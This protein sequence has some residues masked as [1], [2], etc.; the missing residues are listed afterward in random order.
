MRQAYRSDIDGLR[1]VAVLAV[2]FYH[3]GMGVPGGFTGVD[4]FFVISG[5]L[6]TSNLKRDIER[7]NFSILGFYD[8]RIRRIVPAL[9]VMI[10]V[11]LIA[12]WFLLTPGDYAAAGQS[13]TYAAFGLSNLYFLLH[14]GY[15]DRVAEMQPLLHTWSLGVEEQF[16]LVWPVL[17][18]IGMKIV[19]FKR[20][21]LALFGLALLLAFAYGV[22][23]TQH[24]PTRGFYLPHARAWELAIGAI[25]AFMPMVR[26]PFMAGIM[27]VAGI[28]LLGWS[29][30]GLNSTD[31]FPGA[32]AIYA[33]GGAALLAWPKPGW[34]IAATLTSP[35]L[36][37]IGL[38]SYS[39]YLWHWPVLVLFRTYDD[40]ATPTLPQTLA[41]AAVSILLAIA[42]YWFVERPIR[43]MRPIRWTTV[44]SGLACCA[45]V[46]SGSYA[47]SAHE[48]FPQR[49]GKKVA[50][51]SSLEAMWDWTC[52][53]TI[54]FPELPDAACVFGAPWG[55]A[56][57]R[58]LIW[59]DSHSQVM[60]PILNDIAKRKDVSVVLFRSCPPITD[61]EFISEHYPNIP[62]YTDICRTE[63][64]DGARFLADHS[65]ISFLIAASDWF[66]L[67]PQ[68]YGPSSKDGFE[69]MKRGL[70][71]FV[72]DFS[73]PTR[74][75][76][77]I[78]TV[79]QYLNDPVACA[80]G[81]IGPLLRNPCP[82]YRTT[83]PRALFEKRQGQEYEVFHEIAA[84][85]PSV[86]VIFSGERMC[87]EEDCI[88]TLDGQFL[89]RDKTHLRRN[90]HPET[91]S[92]LANILG[93]AKVFEQA[94]A[95]AVVTAHR[96]VPP[97]N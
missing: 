25:L 31:L 69:L 88:S 48:G 95:K 65:D 22:I 70:L 83:I 73:A 32:N 9:L 49:L 42:S 10:A 93:I 45:V 75:I 5:F 3:Y 89:Y 24:S 74:Q 7:G 86:T 12:G 36:R 28:A 23:V 66:S 2:L 46:A 51:M 50:G 6:I 54:K 30:F 15:F 90:L 81:K 44:A 53:Q 56:A 27:E 63:H 62:L 72:D 76:S 21:F 61:G 13:A 87:S 92:D 55:T 60:A 26:L 19:P 34:K 38:I 16:Y 96:S 68:I 33:C 47:L 39:L 18:W 17:L 80:I 79:P 78:A 97:R 84:T 40:G 57:K 64:K 4:V 71:K 82:S 35:P 1:A 29:F 85:F 20:L 94:D 11:T 77:L 91:V 52:P 41:L 59:G 8:R 58:G 37:S 43:H 14:T 67:P